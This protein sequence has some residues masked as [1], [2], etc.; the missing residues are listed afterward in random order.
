MKLPDNFQM[1]EHSRPCRF[2]IT[3]YRAISLSHNLF[4]FVSLNC[5][6][7]WSIGICMMQRLL[8]ISD[9]DSKIIHFTGV[10]SLSHIFYRSYFPFP[11]IL[12]EL[13]PF[14]IYF[15]GVISLSHTFYRSYFPFLYILQE[16]FPFPIHF[17][18]V[19]SLSHTF[20]RSY[21]PFPYI[22]QELFPLPII[23]SKFQYCNYL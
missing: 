14:P 6:I 4:K 21:F 7:F 9:F 13:F 8:H 3:F 1:R 20:Y 5:C 11:Y 10:I 18:G 16:L 22:L 23:F 2:H 19:I 12:Q 17:T 15:T